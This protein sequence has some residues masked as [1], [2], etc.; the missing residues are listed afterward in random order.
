MYAPT[1]YLLNVQMTSQ[2]ERKKK[3]NDGGREDAINYL[4]DY[5]SGYH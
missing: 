4:K 3:G 1:R 2:K 5:E